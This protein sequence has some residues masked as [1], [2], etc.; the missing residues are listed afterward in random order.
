VLLLLLEALL[1]LLEAAPPEGVVGGPGRLVEGAPGRGDGGVH[2]LGSAVGDPTD[3]LLGGR[4]DVVEDGAGFR[5][6]EVPVDPH[7]SLRPAE[8]TH[9]SLLSW[10]RESTASSDDS[11]ARK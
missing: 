4:V 5:I 6:D 1:E 3:H 11:G 9:A 8:V 10:R 7:A 2:V